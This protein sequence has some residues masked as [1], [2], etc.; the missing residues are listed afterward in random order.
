MLH[1]NVH[2]WT[3]KLDQARVIRVLCVDQ[4]Q[5]FPS[6][7]FCNRHKGESV[8]HHTER[9]ALGD[10]LAGEKDEGV[11]ILSSQNQDH[12]VVIVVEHHPS[13][14]CPPVVHGPDHSLLA[15]LVEAVESVQHECCLSFFQILLG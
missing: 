3:N 10:T 15:K 4:L 11:T 14:F 2:H 6:H 1:D 7:S 12:Q 5:D 8:A 9:I 13:A